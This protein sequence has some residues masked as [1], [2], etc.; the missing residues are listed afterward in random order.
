[1]STLFVAAIEEETAALSHA[2]D[3]VHVGVGK[4]QA[5]TALARVLADRRGTIDLVVN[6]GTAGGLHGQ[7]LGTIVEV[8]RVHQHDLDVAGIVGL[9][10]RPMPG[11]PIEV[12]APAGTTG[13]LATG[14]RLIADP[15]D[16]A[17]I[18]V[19][20]DV[21]DMEGYAIAAVCRAFDVPLRIVKAVSDGADG[22][23]AIAWHDALD[24]CARD[25]AAWVAHQGPRG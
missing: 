12:A 1:M 4:V 24:H 5:A 8:A 10:G 25:L 14:D 21:V 3:L 9:L 16:R 18:A 15:A 19:D 6:L 23:A 7:P 17:R 2:V 20:A 13:R 11:G 22:D